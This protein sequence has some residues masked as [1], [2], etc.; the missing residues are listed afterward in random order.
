MPQWLRTVRRRLRRLDPNDDPTAEPLSLIAVL[1]VLVLSGVST[2]FFLRWKIQPMQDLGHHVAMTAV[3]TDYSRAGSI[4]PAIYKP[5]DLL[6]TNSLLYLVAGYTGKIIGPSWAFR[7]WASSYLA[8]VPLA[9]L[10]ALRVFGRSAWGAVMAIPLAYNMSFVFGFT[11]FLFA[12]PFAVLAIPLFYRMMVVPSWKRIIPVAVV[13]TLL[14]LAHVHVFLWTGVMLF[15]MTIVAF[16]VAIRR[17]LVG[18]PGPQPA[19]LALFAMLSVL[20]AM[21]LFAR[22]MW[23]SGQP[24]PADELSLIGRQTVDWATFRASI[25]G[26]GQLLGNVYGTMSIVK[27]DEHASF[28]V[29]ALCLVMVCV[30]I[31]RYHTWKRPPV[32]ELACVMTF[33]SYFFLPENAGGQAVIGSRQI[34]LAMWFAGAFYVPVPA[35]VS[36][37]GRWFVI[38]ASIALT[39]FHLSYWKKLLWRF[40]KE[41]AVGLEEV[42]AAAPPRK[43]LHYVNNLPQ[44]DIFP[45]NTFWHVEKWYMIDKLGQC[46]EN[47][48]W[49]AMNS[50]RYRKS[51]DFHRPTN[52]SSTWVNDSEIWDNFDIILTHRFTPTA[53]E[54][55]TANERG[56]LI[57]SRGTWQ[58]WR[59]KKRPR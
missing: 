17:Q 25:P 29:F 13:M 16:I 8:T 40:E 18:P 51:Y 2:Y 14:F 55:A 26:P 34:G 47:P 58:L 56:E 54:L 35:R 4:Y 50:V 39:V 45:L 33:V 38:G 59:S 42:L 1:V 12:A 23:R 15:T 52:H 31:A 48:A 53:A 28:L 6:N 3:V 21:A 41:E 43:K 49:G 20:P 30:A 37:I 36:L 5:F 22:W 7:L 11:N 9:N 44:S 46:N 24:T 27:G 57:K 19:R 10:Y 32:L